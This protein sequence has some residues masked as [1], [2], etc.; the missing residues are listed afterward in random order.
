[1]IKKLKLK[2]N[3]TNNWPQKLVAL[4]LACFIWAMAPSPSKKGLTEIQFFVPV[5]YINTPKDLEMTSTPLQTV[6]VVVEVPPRDLPDVHPSNFQAVIDL[7]GAAPGTRK[8]KIHKRA[9]KAP[10]AVSIVQVNPESV[11]ITFEKAITKELP[12]QPVLV[13]TPAQGY[14]LE[15]VTMIPARIE[16]HGPARSL[17]GVDQ[18]ETKALN[19][20]GVSGEIEMFAQIAWPEGVK[21]TPAAPDNFTARI[22]VGSE[23]VSR[24]FDKIPI[25]VVNQTYVTR[26]NPKNFN[27]LIRGPKSLVDSMTI[28]DIQAF[29]DL[30]SYKPGTYKVKQ[31]TVRLRPELQ[32]QEAW[33]PIDVWVLNQKIYE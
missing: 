12:I 33:P 24:R 21:P 14:V 17:E 22:Q 9:I 15:K 13:G 31:P 18:L 28:D 6:S 4:V 32:I 23:P 7:D 19:I 27:L 10:K 26:I 1:M 20:E 30:K 16:V 3:L 5:S 2:F 29:I 25:G 8:Y 11:E